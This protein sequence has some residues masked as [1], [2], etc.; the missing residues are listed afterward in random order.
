[1]P[2][3]YPRDVVGNVDFVHAFTG[4][5]SPALRALKRLDVSDRSIDISYRGS[6]QPLEFGRLGYEKRGIGFDVA[7]ATA[8]APDIRVDISSRWEDR[9]GGY[10]WFDFLSQ[11]K[12]VLG[13]ESGSNL[14]RLHG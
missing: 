8:D 11:S 13:A 4:Y 6:I 5:V 1:M 3:V 14:I 9:I 12:V 7:A 2:K 10:A